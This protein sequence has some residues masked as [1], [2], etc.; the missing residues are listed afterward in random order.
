MEDFTGQGV[1]TE[2]NRGAVDISGKKS[3]PR[4]SRSGKFPLL[5]R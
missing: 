4:F 1:G 2:K 5:D 3:I